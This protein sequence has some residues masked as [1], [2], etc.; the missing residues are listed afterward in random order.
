MMLVYAIAS[1]SLCAWAAFFPPPRLVR[2]TNELNEIT[3]TL[4]APREFA[5]S[6]IALDYPAYGQAMQAHEV[7]GPEF[8]HGIPD[9]YSRKIYIPGVDGYADVRAEIHLREQGEKTVIDATFH[10]GENQQNRN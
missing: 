8:E 1:L 7:I 6:L 10:G 3:L 2:D 4:D 9:E 5:A